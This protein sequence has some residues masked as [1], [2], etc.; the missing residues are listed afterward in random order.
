MKTL[1]RH[2]GF[3]LIEL[4]VVIAIVAVLAALLL[5][6][7]GKAREK[8]NSSACLNNLRQ[9]GF[10]WVMY[11]DDNGDRVAPANGLSSWV[12]GKLSPWPN[13][14]DNFDTSLLI[15]NSRHPRTALLGRYVQNAEIFRCPSDRSVVLDAGELRSRV[16]SYSMNVF[17]NWP[18]EPGEGNLW[19]SADHRVFSRL[20]Q[21]PQPSKRFVLL[22]ER[23]ESIN[24]SVFS[25]IMLPDRL[26]DWPSSRHNRAGGF[27]FADGHGEI[28]KWQDERMHPPEDLSKRLPW[29]PNYPDSPDI[30]WLQD[31]ATVPK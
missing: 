1:I 11:A 3:T 16:R 20:S 4:L 15:D 22:G 24:D 9:L 19:A 26:G 30:A 2:R 17:F 29:P 25:T 18:R 6:V 28:R 8:A 23:V 21:V 13:N 14:P 12:G 27:T 7:L 5:P 10:A 31:A